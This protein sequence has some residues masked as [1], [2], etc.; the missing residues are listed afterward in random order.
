MSRAALAADMNRDGAWR[1]SV[2]RGDSSATSLRVYEVSSE[3]FPVQDFRNLFWKAEQGWFAKQMHP[4]PISWKHAA[5]SDG[6][7]SSTTRDAA[8]ARRQWVGGV[9]CTERAN[10][11]RME[12]IKMACPLPHPPRTHRP[13]KSSQPLS[14]CGHGELRGL[15]SEISSFLVSREG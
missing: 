7:L 4:C 14:R 8:P 10:D 6:R 13:T 11:Q 2:D 12:C 5:T 1:T 15:E 9:R 3:L